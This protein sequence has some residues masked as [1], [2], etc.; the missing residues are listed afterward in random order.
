LAQFEALAPERSHRL[1]VDL[2][3]YVTSRRGL[4]TT[5]RSI[6]AAA[7]H[8]YYIVPEEAESDEEAAADALGGDQ[9]VLDVQTHMV[10]PARMSGVTAERLIR[11]LRSMNPD[12]WA[13][14]VDTSQIT[15]AH[16]VRQVFGGSETAVALITSF[17]GR[18]HEQPLTNAEAAACR[19]VVDRYAGTGRVLTHTIIHPNLGR[20]E[21]E[22]MEEWRNTLRPSGWKVYTLWQPSE[23]AAE[24]RTERGW[25]LDDETT[26]IPFLER[27]RELGPHLVCAHKGVDGQIA[28]ASSPSSSPRDIGPAAAAF[29]DIKFLVYHSGYQ[30]DP[31]LKEGAYVED[32]AEDQRWGA[33]RLVASLRA[34]GIG[35]QGNVYGEL[36]STW[37]LVMR[38]PEEA[39]HVLGK[40]LLTLGEDRIVWGTDSVW[41]GPPQFLIDAF[42]AFQIPEWMQER[43]GYPA[44]TPTAKAKILG[45]NGAAAYGVDVEAARAAHQADK[46]EWLDAAERGERE[47]FGA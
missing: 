43:F 42:R 7:G 34:A 3:D 33:D 21:L 6:N 20:Q 11:F 9:L 17:P 12:M 23:W 22:A 44:I 10:N 5:L 37:F 38:R 32:M 16:W 45:L 8:D 40:L 18:E 27:V 47:L 31:N 2:P 28:D 39:A 41:Y 29:P 36:G 24:G 35:P 19:D 25:Y 13:D 1:K 4:A 26:G 15:S 46:L 30:P 14:G